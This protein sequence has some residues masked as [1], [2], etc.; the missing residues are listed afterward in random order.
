M[1]LLTVDAAYYFFVTSAV[2]YIGA[3]HVAVITMI[4][5]VT[6]PCVSNIVFNEPDTLMTVVLQ[7]VVLMAVVY[8]ELEMAKIEVANA[9]HGRAL[10]CWAHCRRAH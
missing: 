6:G 1:L 10:K 4:D 7:I 5:L 2:E 3:T 9:V 8:H